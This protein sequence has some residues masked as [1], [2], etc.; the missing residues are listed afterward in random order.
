MKIG[1][2]VVTYN[3]KELLTEC[4]EALISQNYKL[5]T[6][7]VID[8]K[9][10]DG[11]EEL[12]S[13]KDF[14]FENNI[15]Y[16]RMSENLG[17][18]GG[19]HEGFK[20]AS[21]EDIDWLWIMDDD[22]IAYKDSLSS[23]VEKIPVVPSNTSF[24]SSVV[25]GPEK[26]PMN[27]PVLSERRHENGYTNWYSFLDESLVE[28]EA[29]TFVSLLISIKA[30]RKLGLPVKSYFIWGDDY[31]YTY[32]LTNYFGPAYFVGT[33]KVLHKRFNAKSLSIL[34]ED[35]K[36]RISMYHYF[37]RNNLINTYYYKGKIR[38]LKMY[39]AFLF[40]SFKAIFGKNIK[41][42][43][44]KFFTVHKGILEFIFGMY[45]KHEFQKRMNID[46]K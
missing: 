5:K 42:R 22:T 8:N 21:K 12:F 10:T 11:T 37:Y 27:V 25:Y 20:I 46:D 36:N 18:A 41:Y 31:E 7:I 2:L 44:R 19:F 13:E 39:L 1:A 33:S 40:T 35:N 4:L 3:R 30:I 34:N 45:D 17:G 26:E 6:I 23:F 14:L 32:R 28:I 15:Q 29:A 43:F 38:T 24:L 16:H 9:S